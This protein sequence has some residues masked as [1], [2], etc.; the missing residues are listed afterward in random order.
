MI[1]V[2]QGIPYAFGLD[3]KDPE[4]S[5]GQKH[6]YFRSWINEI[7]GKKGESECFVY[8]HNSRDFFKL[9]N[10]W[11]SSLTWRIFYK[12]YTYEPLT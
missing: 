4:F 6:I 8:T 11:N 5:E 10:L 12:Y 2:E 9:L 3:K 1:L 7:D